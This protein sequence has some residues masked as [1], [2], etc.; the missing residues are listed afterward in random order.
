MRTFLTIAALTWA[1]LDAAMAAAVADP[2][3]NRIGIYF[4]EDATQRNLWINPP[5]FQTVF[6]IV[7]NPTFSNI[8]GW[9]A[10]V[11]GLEA[12]TMSVLGTN[13]TG[14]PPISGPNLQ[15]D[16]TYETPLV[17]QPVTVLA[18]IVGFT[19]DSA[20]CNCLVLTG[21]DQPAIPEGLP[22]I[23]AQEEQ[24]SAI[25]VAHLYANGVAAAINENPIP[26]YPDCSSALA[27]E[28]A[29]WSALK[30]LFR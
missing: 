16:I 24:P 27:A 22:L 3:P 5:T 21:I 4:D 19:L 23:W 10:A 15:Y 20:T 7:T 13:I 28:A 18:T 1:L 6:I 12:W 11:R 29:T 30:A 14:G 17:A 8:Y 9:Q 26:E 25:Q 2:T